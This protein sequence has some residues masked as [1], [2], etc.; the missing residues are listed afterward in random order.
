MEQNYQEY[1]A[2]SERER[3]SLF[4][5]SSSVKDQS[6]EC[7]KA[8]TALKD[9]NVL[10]K[11]KLSALEN[12]QRKW[13]E[14][15]RHWSTTDEIQKAQLEWIKKVSAFP[16]LSTINSPE[17]KK[18]TV[19]TLPSSR[20]PQT[21]SDM[22]HRRGYC[23]YVPG[24]KDNS[25]RKVTENI[26]E[27]ASDVKI[28]QLPDPAKV[29]FGNNVTPMKSKISSSFSPFAESRSSKVDRS[30]QKRHITV[31]K[32]LQCQKKLELNE[33]AKAEQNIEP[34]PNSK[35]TSTTPDKSEEERRA[36]RK[37]IHRKR[38]ERERQLREQKELEEKAEQEQRA[39]MERLKETQHRILANSTKR[40]PKQ[41][42]KEGWVGLVEKAQED[43]P[44]SREMVEPPNYSGAHITG[45]IPFISSR[46]K[47]STSAKDS[48]SSPR[49]SS[50]AEIGWTQDENV[51]PPPEDR[52]D[53]VPLDIIEIQGVQL[54]P[55]GRLSSPIKLSSS[56]TRPSSGSSVPEKQKEF[57][58]QKPSTPTLSASPVHSKPSS[59]EHSVMEV[60]P[61]ASEAELFSARSPL[62]PS[63]PPV[64]HDSDQPEKLEDGDLK[65]MLSFSSE[66][67]SNNFAGSNEKPTMLYDNYPL[68]TTSGKFFSDSQYNMLAAISNKRLAYKELE[69]E[70]LRKQQKTHPNFEITNQFASSDNFG[71]NKITTEKK[72]VD[73]KGVQCQVD[74][75][76]LRYASSTS[77][78][79]GSISS[80]EVK[81]T[82][83]ERLRKPDFILLPGRV[84]DPYLYSRTKESNNDVRMDTTVSENLLVDPLNISGKLSLV[85]RKSL[86][87]N[88]DINR[89]PEALSKDEHTD[90]RTVASAEQEDKFRSLEMKVKS[91]THR[92]LS[93]DFYPEERHPYRKSVV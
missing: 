8:P 3:K 29:P 21:S 86:E 6:S 67:K 85:S 37:Y 39:R 73:E 1:N 40:L 53:N 35:T 28:A 18:D 88:N 71:Y 32:K 89:A 27:H 65:K 30:A 49:S 78:Q 44:L 64:I 57:S 75:E 90:F 91:K 51:P 54:L 69:N 68:F 31:R 13:I 55:P 46:G 14:D 48:K 92:E 80:S 10:T 84:S 7:A 47:P 34:S 74:F 61:L 87:I 58:L 11:E 81:L 23:V 17:K 79:L 63:H 59:R 22:S 60:T 15:M 5:E 50:E 43:K 26:S 4:S 83:S 19:W 2:K 38:V 9:L 70:S 62:T 42:K 82:Q 66:L 20:H 36:A 12:A 56:S 93:Q 76:E 33:P 77:D 52:W 41:R 24:F 25:N 16:T 72:E 45:A